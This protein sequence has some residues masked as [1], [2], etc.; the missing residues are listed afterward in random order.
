MRASSIRITTVLWTYSGIV[1]VLVA[2]L[3]VVSSSVS[4]REDVVN[5]SAVVNL[6][7]W[8]AS[9]DAG[10]IALSRARVVGGPQGVS[11]AVEVR[12]NGGDGTYA[13][14]LAGLKE[15]DAYLEGGHTYRMQVYVR[16]LNASGD[17]VG[18]LMANGNFTHRPTDQSQWAHYRD[19]SWHLLQRTFEVTAPAQSDTSLYVS[20]PPD[21]P[22]RMQF[23]LA[24]LREVSLPHPA[25]AAGAPAGALTFDG[26]PASPVDDH[27]WSHEV[28]GGGWGNEEQQTNTAS[29]SNSY[30]D[31]QGNLVLT[32]RREDLTGPDGI[33]RHYTSARLSTAGKLAIQPGSYVEATIRA[34]VG[35]G[36]LPAFWLLGANISDV[37]W[38]ACGELDVMEATQRSDS[39]VRQTIQTPRLSNSSVNDSYGEFA[40]GGYTPLPQ[41]R[42]SVSHEYGVY[43]DDQ[44]V[45]FYVDRTPTLTLTRQEAFETGR[46]W[47]FGKPMSLVLDVAVGGDAA[48]ADFPVSMQV[49]DI[50]VWHGGVPL[51]DRRTFSFPSRVP[52]TLLGASTPSAAAH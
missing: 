18:I 8:R 7:D 45:Q 36:V 16:D 10:L 24:S 40:P 12:R 14:A 44:L 22:L 23:T 28:G 4:G 5:P 39:M 51:A 29:T 1:A 9:S 43:F 25:V 17:T 19:T 34:P 50:L 41:S 21:G 27:L 49:S 6:S 46:Q 15:P 38:P 11:T 13:F 3:W 20:L 30:L 31:G 33:A 2:G 37:G 52:N 47:P 42:D 32:A 26:P 48:N 35:Q